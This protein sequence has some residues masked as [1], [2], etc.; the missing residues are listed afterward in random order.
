MRQNMKN[1]YLVLIIVVLSI[2]AVLSSPDKVE[3]ASFNDAEENIMVT[4]KD[5]DNMAEKNIELEE[6]IVGVVAGEMPAS[7]EVEALKAQAVAARSYALAKIKSSKTSYDLVTDIT[8][9][10][11]ITE[12]EMRE[13]WK[14]DFTFYYNKIKD[15]VAATKNLVL[16]YDDEIISAY[17]FAMSNGATED[18]SLVFGESRDYLVSVDSSWDQ[19]VKNFLVTTAFSRE[20]FCRK[21]SLDCSNL[22]INNIERS[23]TNRVNT[24]TINNQEFK[25]TTFRTLLGL[26][27]T[28]FTIDINDTIDITTKGYGHGVGMS[29]YGANEMAKDG[30]NYQEIL[31]HYYKDVDIV[32]I[33]V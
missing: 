1:K 23:Q 22:T 10:V 20:E 3:T 16:E 33:D 24:I 17:Y 2:F 21:L 29:Q 8:N 15:A 30:A 4:I 31:F 11:Y 6:Y 32:E 25:G 7:F 14:E 13:K 26:R 18:V 9:Q 28:D 27:S 12:E 19:D 5:T